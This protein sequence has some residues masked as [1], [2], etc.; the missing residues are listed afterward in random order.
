MR[1]VVVTGIG[2]VTPLGVGVEPSWRR[3][4]AGDSGA[5][6]IDRFDPERVACKVAAQVP[7]ADGTGDAAS[8]GD[9][10]FNA[11]D[12]IEP[13]EKR[14]MDEFIKF[15]IAAADMAYKDSGI[16]LRTD[17][18]RARVGVMTGAGIGGLEGIERQVLT[19]QEKGRAPGLAILYYGKLN[20]S[21]LGS[22]VYPLR[23]Q[24]AK[25]R[26]GD[27]VFIWCPRDWRCGAPGRA[28]RRRRHA[29]G[30][31]RGLNL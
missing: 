22:G 21:G 6:R 27:G 28:W 20:Q 11:E 16:E 2:L 24:R 9:A 10:L 5:A 29:S 7:Y 30:G 25:S 17:D 13:K 26:G 23:P 19:L 14:R 8:A 18:E 15:G 3:L 1:R 4:L 31:R 12:W